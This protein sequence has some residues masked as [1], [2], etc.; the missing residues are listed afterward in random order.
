M[1]GE[2][3][4]KVYTKDVTDR[5]SFSF[6]FLVAIVFLMGYC[7]HGNVQVHTI[8]NQIDNSLDCI[9]KRWIIT[10]LSMHTRDNLKI[11]VPSGMSGIWI[12]LFWLRD[13][14][15]TNDLTEY[16]FLDLSPF[17]HCS[18]TT[19]V[20]LPILR[21]CHKPQSDQRNCLAFS[22]CI[23]RVLSQNGLSVIFKI[24]KL[25]APSYNTK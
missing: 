24:F 14:V 23:W 21:Q 16:Q 2:R 13:V 18:R 19:N 22:R 1:A 4:F 11:L 5:F 17:T 15:L 20:N 25:T 8:W 7:Y 10:Y 3:N 12:N 6:F 9:N